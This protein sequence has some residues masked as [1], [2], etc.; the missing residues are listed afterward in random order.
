MNLSGQLTG[1]GEDKRTGMSRL[2]CT[3]SGK[4]GEYGQA[5]GIGLARPGRAAAEDV[6]AYEGVGNRGFL[7]RKR[8]GN[9]FV[10]QDVHQAL[11]KAEIGKGSHR[12]PILSAASRIAA[13]ESTRLLEK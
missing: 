3:C 4:A 6:F 1:R 8:F 13:F 11:G 5:K 12:F 10:V 9:A 7:N 2:G